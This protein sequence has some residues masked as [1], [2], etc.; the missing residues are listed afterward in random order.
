MNSGLQLLDSGLPTSESWISDSIVSGIPDSLNWVSDSKAQDSGFHKYKFPAFQIPDYRTV[1]DFYAL[2]W[3]K[4]ERV[5]GNLCQQP[6]TFFCGYSTFF[7]LSTSHWH[8]L[9]TVYNNHKFHLVSWLVLHLKLQIQRLWNK[10]R[11]RQRKN[12][13]KLPAVNITQ[14]V[15]HHVVHQELKMSVIHALC[16]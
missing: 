6:F 12:N 8:S 15:S 10:M 13:G 11:C 14:V 16:T 3:N 5:C 7:F 1:G 9:F 4:N 2:N